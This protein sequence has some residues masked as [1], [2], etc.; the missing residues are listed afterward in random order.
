MSRLNMLQS[1]VNIDT[2]FDF[3]SS[4]A[5]RAVPKDMNELA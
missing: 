2:S 4:G 3:G 1:R 5:Q